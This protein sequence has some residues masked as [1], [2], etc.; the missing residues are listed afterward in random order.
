MQ[1][2]EQSVA[3]TIMTASTTNCYNNSVCPYFSGRIVRSPE[4]QRQA[5]KRERTLTRA[6]PFW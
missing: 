5:E 4:K 2:F 6:C 1:R 3:C